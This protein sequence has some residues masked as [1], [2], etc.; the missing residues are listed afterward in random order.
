MTQK[1]KLELATEALAQL[2][3]ELK[4]ILGRAQD[5]LYDLRF[6]PG[7]ARPVVLNL[8]ANLERRLARLVRKRP[9]GK[10]KSSES[11]HY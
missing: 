1:E 2:C 11:R 10:R 8:G 5:V 6:E 3:G 4:D 9:N 7:P